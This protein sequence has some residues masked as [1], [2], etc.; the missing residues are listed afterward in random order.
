MSIPKSLK[1]L[2]ASPYGPP[3]FFF[4]L[5][6]M[7]YGWFINQLGF[8]WDDWQI[9][10]LKRTYGFEGLNHLLSVGGRPFYIW[11]YSLT[12]SLL[13]EK[14]LHWH[15]FGL[16]ARWLAVV[17]MWWAL[18]QLWPK[19]PGV[20]TWA[21]ALFAVYPIFYLQPLAIIMSQDF[22]LYALFFVSFGSMLAAQRRPQHQRQ[23]T[24][25]AL[26]TAGL[27][28]FTKEYY[29]GLELLRPL[30]LWLLFSEQNGAWRARLAKTARTYAPYLAIVLA[31]TI[32]RLFILEAPQE[33]NPIVFF[34]GLRSNFWGTWLEALQI[35]ARNFIFVIFEVWSRAV[36]PGSLELDSA[37]SLFSWALIPL[38]ALLAYWFMSQF[39]DEAGSAGWQARAMAFGAAGMLLGLIPTLLIGRDPLSGLFADRFN[40]PTLF[41]AAVF[42][43]GM[44]SWL[45]TER[46]RQMLVLAV[47]LG[48]AMAILVRRTNDFRWAWDEQRDFY[49]QLV[50]RAPSI[51]PGSAIL[52]DG[53]LTVFVDGFTPA[54][55]ISLL[56]PKDAGQTP[57]QLNI[58]Y[59]DI[60]DFEGAEADFLAGMPLLIEGTSLSFS[61]D[62]R[63]ALFVYNE[64]PGQC[65]W[66]LSPHDADNHL[67]PAAFRSLLP[68]ANLALVGERGD[69]QHPP[70]DIFGPEPERGWCFY[71]Q[72]AELARQAGDWQ[73]VLSLW[74]TAQAAGLGP[75]SSLELMP[76]IEAY[77]KQGHWQEAF[78]LSRDMYRRNQ[79]SRTQLCS[80]WERILGET[81]PS[82]ARETAAAE[83]VEIVRCD[84]ASAL[85]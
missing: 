30:A 15:L 9:V 52:G 61:G 21:A 6:V 63:K 35:T 12:M 74:G 36:T 54:A 39:G 55:A 43:L 19:R 49:W 75:N 38:G 50:W 80:N 48:L 51:E 28:I 78:E 76:F 81:Y 32:W 1:N 68:A 83:L 79:A 58:M 77:A 4:V 18:R 25:L 42:M 7:A 31:F 71:Y 20:A 41:G 24:A 3:A 56:Y 62:S 82:Q 2:A 26:F 85:D 69:A 40:L 72:K 47:L 8:Y 22:L 29:L 37:F 73:R 46:R 66:L 53:A 70:L 23:F 59:L 65:L 17:A 84:L 14:P 16:V 44:V 57:R 60:H 27:H 34:D 64:E 45:V 5:L 33:Q 11:P 67:L 13:G 10:F